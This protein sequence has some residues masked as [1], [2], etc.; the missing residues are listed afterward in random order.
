M[1]NPKSGSAVHK[2][3][4]NDSRFHQSG[5]ASLDISNDSSL[6]ISG[7]MDGSVNLIHAGTGKIISCALNHTAGLSV[8]SVSFANGMSL[9]ATGGVDG[10]INVWDTSNM[11]LRFS[12]KH[13]VYHWLTF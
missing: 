6:I 13:D 8:E 3:D 7:G 5:V 9:V 10:I 11:K 1:W 4:G 2:F 12:V